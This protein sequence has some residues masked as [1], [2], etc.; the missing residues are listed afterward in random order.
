MISEALAKLKEV[1]FTVLEAR[2]MGLSKT[3]RK[4]GDWFELKIQVLPEEMPAELYAV[5]LGTRM[6]L[7]MVQIGDDETPV[8]AKRKFEDLSPSQQAG[9]RCNDPAFRHWLGSVADADDAADYVRHYCG[10]QSRADLNVGGGGAEKW[11]TL[12]AQFVSD[13]RLPEQR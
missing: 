1:G 4:D 6:N 10:V 9:I 3:R 8:K 13:T 11:R 12:N 2:L 5:P 7:A